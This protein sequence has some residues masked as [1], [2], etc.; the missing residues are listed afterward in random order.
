M[1]INLPPVMTQINISWFWYHRNVLN[2]ICL[3]K[4]KIGCDV[5]EKGGIKIANSLA[6]FVD[7]HIFSYFVKLKEC[8][9][10]T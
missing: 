2:F 10:K 8:I 4:I 3:L 5:M 6:E 1:I 7:Y 9:K